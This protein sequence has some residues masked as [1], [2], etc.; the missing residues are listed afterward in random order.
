MITKTSEDTIYRQ[1][2]AIEKEIRDTPYHKG[3]EHHIGRL[4][5]RLARLRDS[6]NI[7]QQSR[8][9]SSGGYAVRKQGDATVVLVGPPSVGKST[10]INR[11]TNAQ[12]KVAPYA[13]TTVSVI[14]GMLEYKQAKIQ[15][16]DVPGL[17]KG[18]EEGRGR[19]REVLSVVRGC[20]LICFITDID[21]IFAFDRIE[22]A[23]Y[24]NGVRVNQTPPEILIEKKTSGG[25]IIKS[26]IKQDFSKETIIN[27][28]NEMGL[29]NAE[30]TLNEKV[31]LDRLIDSIS[32][33]RVYIPAIYVI[34]K[35][36]DD[37]KRAYVYKKLKE[38]KDDEK[39][40]YIMISAEKG[41]GL[42]D[43]LSCVWL[44]LKFVTVYLVKPDTS[45]SFDQP[46]IM[47]TGDSLADVAK[48]ISVDFYNRTKGAKIW[49]AGSKFPAQEVSLSTKV[50]EGMQILF[51]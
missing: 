34:N 29:K 11:L 2:E 1:I 42:E 32:N 48:K 3:T 15:L 21:D 6:L 37:Y 38:L 5:A 14:P 20:D 33:N 40:K 35:V 27:I 25:I 41:V 19:G 44:E 9:G 45:P 18:A 17:I 49:G 47:K 8:G 36:D 31:T 22:E 51:I 50:V 26:N 13:F 16:L 4:R 30:I 24:K 43:L 10:L 12:S 23:L 46:L 7:R 28:C 39:R